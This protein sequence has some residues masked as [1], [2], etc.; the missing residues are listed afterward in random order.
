MPTIDE[1]KILVTAEVNSAIAAL[2]K[3]ESQSKSTGVG[4]TDLAKKIAGY[5]TASQL[6]VDIG[7]KVISTLGNLAKEGVTTAAAWEK[8]RVSWGVLVGDVEKGNA[9]FDEL[10]AFAAKT[11]LSFDAINQAATTLKGFGINAGDLVETMQM[12][13]DVSQ[14]NSESLGQLALVFGQVKAQGKAMTQDLYQFVNAGIPIFQLL[15]DSMGVSAGEVKELA[16]QSRI[17]FDEIEKALSK[18]TEAGGQFYG[19]MDKTAETTAGKWSTAQDNFKQI[20]ADLGSR[21]LPIVNDALD[22]FNDKF[23]VESIDDKVK[24]FDELRARIDDIS[25]ALKGTLD[26]TSRKYMEAGLNGLESQLQA[27]G[28]EIRAEQILAGISK[29][30]ADKEKEA[31]DKAKDKADREA[32]AIAR[33]QKALELITEA[34]NVVNEMYLSEER[35]FA[36]LGDLID[37]QALSNAAWEEA[38]KLITESNGLIT[39]ANP[40]YKALVQLSKD[41]AE[42]ARDATIATDSIVES[43]KKENK[44]L[45]KNSDLVNALP[46]DAERTLEAYKEITEELSKWDG[47]ISSVSD[48]FSAFSDLSNNQ[49]EQEIANLEAQRDKY[50]ENSS[51]YEALDAQVQA[52]KSELAQKQFNADKINSIASAIINGAEAAVKAYAELGPVAGSIAAGVIAGLTATQVAAIGAQ[53]YTGYAQGGIITSPTHALIGENG[54]EA[55]IPLRDGVT[56][57]TQNITVVQNVSGSIWRT[58]DLQSLAVGAVAKA[59]RGY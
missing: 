7:K 19:M 9:V 39:E 28:E 14:G 10:L 34:N 59:S 5:T 58:K 21:V 56:G 12:L 51:E 40:A 29:A 18:A 25:K 27:L 36:A 46:S 55:I 13:G 20:L 23:K 32:E 38:E 53:Q 4:F 49:A 26:A 3:T 43:I 35:Q 8:S 16:A 1:L 44:E 33:N 45:K 52:K 11:P 41:Y 2:Q 17:T 42:S 57:G 54:P 48:T 6:A 50:E 30:R 24:R 47:V 37:Y 22:A 15:A 31:A